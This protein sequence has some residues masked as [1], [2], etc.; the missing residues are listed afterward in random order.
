MVRE[1]QEGTH[2]AQD[3]TPGRAIAAAAFDAHH[4]RIGMGTH[5]DVAGLV[6]SRMGRASGHVPATRLWLLR[7]VQKHADILLDELRDVKA[8]VAC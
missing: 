4:S 8:P 5:D 7:A 1:T 2:E 3:S 6:V